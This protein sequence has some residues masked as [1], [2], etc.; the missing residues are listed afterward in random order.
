MRS[1]LRQR[2]CVQIRPPACAGG[3]LKGRDGYPTV[4]DGRARQN[5]VSQR[6]RGY[7][8]FGKVPR[9]PV[10]ELTEIVTA[11]NEVIVGPLLQGVTLQDRIADGGEHDDG[12]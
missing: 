5:G 9:Q 12:R 4:I 7:L 1:G 6:E 10:A 11:L 3:G 8:L 2:P